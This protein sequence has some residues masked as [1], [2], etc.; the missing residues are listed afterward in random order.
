LFLSSVGLKPGLKAGIAEFC[1]LGV[2]GLIGWLSGSFCGIVVLS[3]RSS[4][5]L[6]GNLDGGRSF[7]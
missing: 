7:A 3:C 4:A 5:T 1:L 2:S 6:S